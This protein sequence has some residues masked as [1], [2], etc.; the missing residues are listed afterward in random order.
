MIKGA[1]VTLILP[2]DDINETNNSIE[3]LKLL[4]D[5]AGLTIIETFIQKRD[6]I[7]PAFYIGK[8]K[9]LQINGLIKKNN[10]EYIIFE[11]DL[12]P[13]QLA[14]LQDEFNIP[15]LDRTALI[16]EIFRQRAKTNEAKLQVELAKLLYDLPHLKQKKTVTFS[17]Q[18]GIKGLKG[19]GE[20][21]LELD[22]RQ[23][24][25]RILILK[26]KLARIKKIRQTQRINRK[27]FIT[28]SLI[29]YTN[30]GKSTLLK[31]LTKEDVFIEDKLFA[32]LDPKSCRLTYFT[33][34]K[35][36]ITDTVGFIRNLPHSL[37]EAFKATLEEVIHSNIL[38][39][40]VDISKKDFKKDIDA[41]YDVLKELNVN[42][43]PIITVF[44]KIDKLEKNY[45]LNQIY[46]Y[47]NAVCIS[48]IYRQN[49]DL[50]L[51]KI[52][53]VIEKNCL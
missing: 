45:L 42:D 7:D 35:V 32:T 13:T 38:I 53:E 48:A 17:Q 34:K 1:I 11:K 30:S 39:N 28:I 47:P 22:K 6:K 12:S 20:K 9:V 3:E 26:K 16:L 8:G 37:I 40:I 46:S 33:D 24:K 25:R 44:N 52:K 27:D 14:N 50:L 31:T 19:P 51:E 10:I 2:D 41:V 15:V 5:T 49:I 36:I 4:C 29:G 43:K 21:K 18:V 23:I